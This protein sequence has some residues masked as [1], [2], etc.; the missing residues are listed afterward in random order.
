[1]NTLMIKDDNNNSDEISSSEN[2]H[3][4]KLKIIDLNE[5]LKEEK[6]KNQI[7]NNINV[8]GEQRNPRTRNNF[9]NIHFQS[10]ET[11]A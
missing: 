8:T 7:E 4:P 11:H 10:S 6:N 5:N 3:I 1:M 2:N 9:I